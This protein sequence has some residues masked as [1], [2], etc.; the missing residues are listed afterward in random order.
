V[1]GSTTAKDAAVGAHAPLMK[2]ASER[3]DARASSADAMLRTR[4]A[5]ADDADDTN[6]DGDTGGGAGTGGAT[7]GPRAW[8]LAGRAGPRPRAHGPWQ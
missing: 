7:A 8:L 1:V 6:A 5:G 3:S 4:T 2:T